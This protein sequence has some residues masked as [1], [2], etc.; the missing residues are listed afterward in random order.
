[1]SAPRPGTEHVTGGPPRAPWTPGPTVARTPAPPMGQDGAPARQ[2]RGT[3]QSAPHPSPP[4]PAPP[5]PQDLRSALTSRPRVAAASL[6][7]R[8][9]RAAL[10]P[11]RAASRAAPVLV[12]VPVRVLRGAQAGSE[13]PGCWSTALTRPPPQ[14][15]L[16]PAPLSGPPR[17]PPRRAGPA[18]KG[19]ERLGEVGAL[20]GPPAPSLRGP[21]PPLRG[22]PLSGSGGAGRGSVA[23]WPDAGARGA[24]SS[25]SG[26]ARS[27]APSAPLRI[28]S[29]G[30]QGSESPQQA[31]HAHPALLRKRPSP[32]QFISPPTAPGSQSSGQG[33]A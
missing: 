13:P 20:Q 4:R 8:H 9:G 26:G 16:R 33:P 3:G 23:R 17:A 22:S 10:A 12:Q 21:A 19:L 31:P 30:S 28:G 7:V 32:D 2:R 6:L 11:A 15:G 5:Q 18:G 24:H 14:P 1:M 25:A 27:Q 29:W